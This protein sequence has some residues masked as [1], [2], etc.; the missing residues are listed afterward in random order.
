M[1]KIT[2]YY[3]MFGGIIV[4]IE[5][6]EAIGHTLKKIVIRFDYRDLMNFP[7]K[8]LKAIQKICDKVD[9]TNIETTNLDSFDFSFSDQLTDINPPNER[10]LNKMPNYI[11]YND[12][13]TL[14]VEINQFFI[15]I[16]HNVV[17]ELTRFHKLLSLFKNI[18]GILFEIEDFRSRR[19]SLT[20]INDI[21]YENLDN[22]LTDFK[23]QQFGTLRE[24]DWEKPTSFISQNLNYEEDIFFHNITRHIESGTIKSKLFIRLLL[25]LELIAFELNDQTPEEILNKMNSK[26]WTLY[27]HHVTSNGEKKLENNERFGDIE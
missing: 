14:N 3:C 25:Q 5:Q 17:G 12:D 16:T 13:E 15:R 9:L 4:G 10:L 24:L 8:Q 1:M 19:L 23:E 6:H 18:T 11:F 2:R 22:L 27:Y 26:L 21:F 20:K 7:D